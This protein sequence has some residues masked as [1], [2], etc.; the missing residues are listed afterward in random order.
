MIGKTQYC[1]NRVLIIII[2]IIII[3]I[4]YNWTK[5]NGMNMYQNK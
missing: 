1:N 3:I 4:G 5:N 2:I